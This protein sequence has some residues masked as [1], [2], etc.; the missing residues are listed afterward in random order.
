MNDKYLIDLMVQETIQGDIPSN[1]ISLSSEDTFQLTAN[2]IQNRKCY[3]IQRK[4]KKLEVPENWGP[5]K[6][7]LSQS[8][9]LT[10]FEDSDDFIGVLE[11][12]FDRELKSVNINIQG[13]EDRVFFSQ[14]G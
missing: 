1:V 2:Y 5:F 13:R 7:R 9:T 12:F 10:A 4:D 8:F 11:L 3:Q 6:N 14:A